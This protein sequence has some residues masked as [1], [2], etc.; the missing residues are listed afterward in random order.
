MTDKDISNVSNNEST[1]ETINYANCVNFLREGKYEDA[2]KWID[3]IKQ[4]IIE[5][6]GKNKNFWYFGCLT[7]LSCSCL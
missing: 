6:S 2:K 3:T 4:K 1:D 5:P 7:L